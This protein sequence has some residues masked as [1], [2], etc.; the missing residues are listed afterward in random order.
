MPNTFI[1]LNIPADTGP[2]TAS[3]TSGLGCDKSIVVDGDFIGHVTIEISND[4]AGGAGTGMVEAASFTR[5]GEKPLPI[6][7][8]FMRVNVKN[9]VSGSLTVGVGAQVVNSQSISIPVPLTV[10]VGAS[11]DISAFGNFTSIVASGLNVALGL[12]TFNPN[13]FVEVSADGTNFSELAM[14]IGEDVQ[15]FSFL[16]ATAVRCRVKETSFAGIAGSLNLTACDDPDVGDVAGPASS[17]LNG[18]ATYG[19]TTGKVLLSQSTGLLTATALSTTVPMLTIDGSNGMPGFAF[20]SN[21]LTGVFLSAGGQLNFTNNSTVSMFCSSAGLR[22]DRP[23][24]ESTPSLRINRVNSG[25]FAPG[26]AGAVALST[27][28]TEAVLW[29]EFQTQRNA[30]SILMQELAVAAADQA[31]FGQWWILNSSPNVPMFTDDTGID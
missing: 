29:D 25:L 22:I 1:T 23:G 6:A 16:I 15:T 12:N 8:R 3:D 20:V 11:V 28:G 13:L 2:G 30:A 26:A 24:S 9:I 17:T 31:G 7:A 27:A 10:G 4:A 18:I 5:A 19:D 14:F 21:T